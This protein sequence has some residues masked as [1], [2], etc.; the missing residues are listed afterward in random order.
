[1]WKCIF[2]RTL[3][4]TG[5]LLLLLCPP[6]VRGISLS[7][8][9]AD[10]VQEILSDQETHFICTSEKAAQWKLHT[11]EQIILA[12][13]D[14]ELEQLETFNELFV[15]RIIDAH[16]S[17]MTIKPVNNARVYDN[18][19]LLNGS[20]ECSLTGEDNQSASCGLNYVYPPQ[21]VSCTAVNSLWSVSVSCFI[22]SVY[23]SRK[24]YTCQLILLKDKLKNETLESVS[25][26]TSPTSEKF[27][28]SEVKVSGSCV[29]STTLPPEEGTYEFFVSVS[30][31]GRH[32]GTSDM[33][34]TAEPAKSPTTSCE[35]Q[36]YVLENTNITCTC[37][38]TS[39]GHPAG[40]LRWTRGNQTNKETLVKEVSTPQALS[41]TQ[42]LTQSDHSKTW[43]RCDVLWGTKEILGENYTA[44][45][46]CK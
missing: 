37:R 27:T 14:K 15:G 44:N 4:K 35:P 18:I 3:W 28:K 9:G 16:R 21:D 10:G 7:P 26:V 12:Q 2:A 29:F 25:M 6:L 13:Y 45:V 11:R 20:L 23:S 41:H 31:G 36:P 8:C 19:K 32:F 38:I 30:P 46:G 40:Y 43:F 33:L 22:K 39:L 1:M 24:N 17:S 5:V 34:F 42:L